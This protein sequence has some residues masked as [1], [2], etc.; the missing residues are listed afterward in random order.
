MPNHSMRRECI[1]GYSREIEVNPDV[2]AIGRHQ[3][4]VFLHLVVG[5]VFILFVPVWFRIW[6]EMNRD[7]G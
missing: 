4:C 5:G 6:L 1:R 3:G 2:F 7:K